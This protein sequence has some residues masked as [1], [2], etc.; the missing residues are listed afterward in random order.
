MLFC[1]V[2]IVTAL[3]AAE[4]SAQVPLV[5]P[6]EI[7]LVKLHAEGAQIYACKRGPIWSFRTVP[8]GVS[9]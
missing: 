3:S 5:A 2:S 4:A 6:D 8:S 7:V 1:V 9:Q